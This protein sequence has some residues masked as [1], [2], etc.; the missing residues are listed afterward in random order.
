MAKTKLTPTTPVLLDPDEIHRRL[1]RMG[2]SNVRFVIGLCILLSH[3]YDLKA[4]HDTITAWPPDKGRRLKRE[5]RR[6]LRAYGWEED[7]ELGAG[8]G[9]HPWVTF[10][11]GG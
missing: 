2:E 6:R 5:V 7:R 4:T 11:C 10:A 9:V 3:H 1:A 8:N